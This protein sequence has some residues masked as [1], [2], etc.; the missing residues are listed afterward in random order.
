MPR[1]LGSFYRF[2][3]VAFM[4]GLFWFCGLWASCNRR[5]SRAVD[6]G[7]P[8]QATTRAARYDAAAD[9][10]LGHLNLGEKEKIYAS[11]SKECKA[12]YG[13]QKLSRDAD[14]IIRRRGVLLS[15]GAPFFTG[16]VARIPVKASSANGSSGLALDP[17][18]Q[19]RGFFFDEPR[20]IVI[21][22][23]NSVRMPALPRRV[24][25]D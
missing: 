6:E 24:V 2:R 12:S 20:S 22:S 16:D 8:L 11:M 7:A 19:I 1:T 15:H 21:P 14:E 3:R 18:G 23:R 10:L 4:F 13:Y 5:G 25:G 9:K 17:G